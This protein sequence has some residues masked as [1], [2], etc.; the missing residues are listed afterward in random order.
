M[1]AVVCILLVLVALALAAH[2]SVNGDD[3]EAF[4]AKFGKKYADPIEEHKRKT[5]FH[6]NLNNAKLLNQQQTTATFGATKFA[7]LHPEEFK[8][9]YLMIER[10]N[11]VHPTAP[12][13]KSSGKV[14]ALPTSFD[15][16]GT[17]KVTPVKNQGQCGSCWAFSCTETVESVWAVAG[18]TI[19]V[20]SEQ[21]IVDC[22]TLD[23]GCDGGWPYDAYKYLMTAGGQDTEASY[24]YTGVDGTCKFKKA[25]I[26][27]SLTSW[28]YVTENKNET[29]MAEY[30][31]SNSPISVCVDAETWQLYQNGVISA[32]CGRSI[33]H[34]VQITGWNVES[35]MTAWHVRNSW[36]TDWGMNGY[37]WVKMGGNICDIAAVVTVPEVPAN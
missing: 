3:W 2:P 15:W 5:I 10:K 6:F 25:D 22:D 20:L 18:H 17:D 12:V 21:Q 9:K 31:M 14:G 23:D 11:V 24:P 28:K 7:D 27:A 13:W 32:N 8:Q 19:P 37:L 29:E 34:C 26:A 36:G 33:D 4:K 30:V 35:S 16:C 1:K